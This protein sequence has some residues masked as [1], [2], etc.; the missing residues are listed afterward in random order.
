MKVWNL[1]FSSLLL[2]NTFSCSSVSAVNNVQKEP[3]VTTNSNNTLKVETT[4]DN[5][6]PIMSSTVGIALKPVYPDIQNYK[7]T[8]KT[9]N[10]KFLSWNNQV[11]ELGKETEYNGTDIYWSYEFED[12]FT[13]N[14]IKVSVLNKANNEII[15]TKTVKIQMNNGFANVIKEAQPTNNIAMKGY[16]LYTWKENDKQLFALLTGTNRNK[17]PEEIKNSAIDF[18]Q[19]KS[20]ISEL[21]KGETVTLVFAGMYASLFPAELTEDMKKELKE[22]CN[23]KGIN[24]NLN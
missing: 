9:N 6:A 3:A 4:P 15:Q 12:K 16:E 19:L 8:F 18:N 11:K 21:A 13:E 17:M 10:G 23:N 24:L 20:K 2:I 7:V 22:I 5:Y 14:E 1:L